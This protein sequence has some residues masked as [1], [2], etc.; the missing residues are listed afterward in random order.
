L[1]T[2]PISWFQIAKNEGVP[3]RRDKPQRQKIA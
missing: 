1:A 2:K 3:D